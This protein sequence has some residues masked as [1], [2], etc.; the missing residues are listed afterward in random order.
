MTM[1]YKET[2]TDRVKVDC[3]AVA[4]M[5]LCI[6]VNALFKIVDPSSC[7]VEVEI[8]TVGSQVRHLFSQR[9]SCAVVK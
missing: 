1:R 9:A 6:L 7:V 4:L 3:I 2:K 8:V 5:Y